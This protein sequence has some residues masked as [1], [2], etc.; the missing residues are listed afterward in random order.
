MHKFRWIF[1]TAYSKTN[2]IFLLENTDRSSIICLYKR[3]EMI[4]VQGKNGSYLNV[5]FNVTK[6]VKLKNKKSQPS[7]KFNNWLILCGKPIDTKHD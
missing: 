4:L 5:G 7:R 2:N 3:S 1:S 6:W